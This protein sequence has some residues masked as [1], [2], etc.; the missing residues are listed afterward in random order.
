MLAF[1]LGLYVAANASLWCVSHTCRMCFTI[2]IHGPPPKTEIEL[3]LLLAI[4]G[5]AFYV[6]LMRLFSIKTLSCCGPIEFWWLMKFIRMKASMRPRQIGL[7]RHHW[8]LKVHF[9]RKLTWSQKKTYTE[10]AYTFRIMSGVSDAQYKKKKIVVTQY[11]KI[12]YNCAMYIV[13]L[14]L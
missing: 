8:N 9:S 3:S 14:P 7:R 5:S 13:Y 4:P 6:W 10:Q 11:I 1:V 2:S 12:L